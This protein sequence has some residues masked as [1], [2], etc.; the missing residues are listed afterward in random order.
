M[1]EI[2]DSGQRIEFST[3]SQRDMQTGK[4]RFDLIF[5]HATWQGAIHSEHGATKYGPRNILLGQPLG[6]L[7]SS[8]MRHLVKALLGWTDEKH[9]VAA[10]WNLDAA[11][12]MVCMMK[13]GDFSEEKIKQIDDLPVRPVVYDYPDE[14]KKLEVKCCY[15]HL[16]KPKEDYYYLKEGDEIKRGDEYYK[17]EDKKWILTGLPFQG[18]WK[19]GDHGCITKYRRKL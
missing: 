9:L 12:E 13:A 1:S 3:G 6:V 5:P 17:E 16:D 8:A 15:Q 7:I 2:K 4:G 14:P 11:V 10:K 18:H 19:M